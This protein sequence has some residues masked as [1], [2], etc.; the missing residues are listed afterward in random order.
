MEF[1][2][3]TELP[4]LNPTLNP[5]M[6]KNNIMQNQIKYSEAKNLRNDISTKIN[7]ASNRNL[8]SIRN[9]SSYISSIIESISPQILNRK[10]Q[11][12]SL[13]DE[14]NI[15]K[16]K[17]EKVNSDIQQVRTTSDLCQIKLDLNILQKANKRFRD[18]S[19]D[20][21]NISKRVDAA[22]TKCYKNE[23]KIKEKIKK[24]EIWLDFK[25]TE[26]AKPNIIKVHKRVDRISSF[27]QSIQLN[28]MLKYMQFYT[29]SANSINEFNK[30]FQR[31]ESD[32]K[33]KI[34][35]YHQ[36]IKVEKTNILNLQKIST[37]LD[38]NN[39]NL[40]VDIKESE[41]G[42]KNLKIQIEDRLTSV[43]KMIKLLINSIND[44]SSLMKDGNSLKIIEEE[45][46][47]EIKKLANDWELFHQNNYTVQNQ[48]YDIIDYF[49]EKTSS[50]GTFLC[51]LESAENLVNYCLKRISVWKAEEE[52]KMALF[53]SDEKLID[54]MH[55]LEE[56]V[57]IAE[58]KIQQ[59]DGKKIE[60]IPSKDKLNEFNLSIPPPPLPPKKDL[61]P[62]Y[63][64]DDL[65]LT[66]N[67]ELFDGDNNL[68]LEDELLESSIIN[69]SQDSEKTRDINPVKQKEEEEGEEEEKDEVLKKGCSSSS[70]SVKSDLSPKLI[71][72]FKIKRRQKRYSN[73][74]YIPFNPIKRSDNRF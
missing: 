3:M 55:E 65:V 35:Y 18:F 43:E 36:Q 68:N 13:N 1:Q 66:Y 61:K 10:Q 56:K 49:D 60:N 2:F 58:E 11:E 64:E 25:Q 16:Y 51:R 54:K 33:K 39:K 12:S 24:M 23:L 20:I 9:K 6:M 67:Q 5:E 22:K 37:Y 27:I 57:R 62:F 42:F 46:M 7:I 14:M 31:Y 44:P 50:Q 74:C 73:R 52:E 40:S 26:M 41:D 29:Q 8:E 21:S 30:V 45:S 59:I 34:Q 19:A 47:D 70:I 17:V 63:I 72:M 15:L 28:S 53:E 71:N 48:V 4:P 38:N 32:I 69:V